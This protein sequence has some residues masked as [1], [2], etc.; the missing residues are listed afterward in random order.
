[1]AGATEIYRAQDREKLVQRLFEANMNALKRSAPRAGGD[2]ARLIRI[3]YNSIVYDEKLRECTQI[4]LMGGVL[5]ALKLGLTLGGPM[6]EAWLLPFR[7]GKTGNLEATMIIGYQGFRNIIDRGK[8]VLT[9][10][11]R[12]V[13]VNDHFEYRFGDDPRIFHDP[14]FQ[15]VKTEADLRAAYCVALLRGNAKERE[16]L[17]KAEIDQHRAR[18]RAS[19]AG[20]WVTDYPA[21]ALKTVIRKMSKYLPKSSEL[22]A[23]AID[24]D[25]RADRGADQN[26]ET[27][28]LEVFDESSPKAL[29]E[30]P[31]ALDTLKSQMKGEKVPASEL[32]PDPG[33]QTNAD[34][35]R[36]IEA[37]DGADPKK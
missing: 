22:L 14:P 2:P 27:D 29:S 30:A 8:A 34:L 7:N 20:P 24:L 9:M 10:Y 33:Q 18:S 35:D 21:M 17:E 23:R 16:V 12:A 28:G 1:M 31:S 19:K 36:E 13:H 37:R 15:L 3:A 5:E 32:R 25:E 4:S 11:P 6:Q 26:F